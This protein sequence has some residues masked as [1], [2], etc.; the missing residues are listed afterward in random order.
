MLDLKK[1]HILNLMSSKMFITEVKNKTYT[2]SKVSKA[3]V[4]CKSLV[5]RESLHSCNFTK[6]TR[7]STELLPKNN[8]V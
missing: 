2:K 5:I 6:S 8:T 3:V 4:N 7:T 1:I